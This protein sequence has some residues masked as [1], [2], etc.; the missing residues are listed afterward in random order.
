MHAQLA[1]NAPSLQSLKHVHVL[2]PTSLQ[3]QLLH[4]EAPAGAAELAKKLEA[5]GQKAEA[6]EAVSGSV[7]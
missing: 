1:C 4:V 6:L 3:A 2:H 5:M 7:C